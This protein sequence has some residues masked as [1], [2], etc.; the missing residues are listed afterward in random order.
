MYP[1]FAPNRAFFLDVDGTL[2]ALAD[3]PDEVV[4]PLDLIDLLSRLYRLNDEAVALISGR[5]IRD[6]DRL[7][8][9]LRMPA[10]GQHGLER[11]DHGGRLHYHHELDTRLDGIRE[12]LQQFVHA[13]PGVLLE[14]K[15]FS[16]A[17][18]Y[19]Q[20]PEKEIGV[21]AFIRQLMPGIEQ[22][23]HVLKGKMVF[24]IKPGGR[25]KG[26][27]IEEF[28]VEAPFR[29]RTPVFIG[30]DVTDE[31]GFAVVNNLGG[32]SIKVGDGDSAAG[33]HL[34]N[35]SCVMDYLNIYTAGLSKQ[36][37]DQQ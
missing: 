22:E 8:T 34:E 11:R 35:P 10:A 29:N 32:Y 13:N 9:P 28:M 31:D 12:R 20:A 27:A 26:M 23:F 5:T 16:L 18:H 37:Q 25:N 1:P 36:Q 19:R 6:L 2:L 17:V 30:D 33:W 21:D 15:G 3:N 7:F 24:E 14:D 4:V